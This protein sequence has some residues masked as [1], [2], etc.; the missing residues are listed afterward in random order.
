MK[1]DIRLH[2]PPDRG[3]DPVDDCQFPAPSDPQL[4]AEG[5]LR[6]HV[7]DK[8]R[9][10][11]SIELYRS[12]GFEVRTV[13]LTDPE[14]AKACAGCAPAFCGSHVVIYTRKIN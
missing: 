4:V 1:K 12:L 14:F 2:P 10:E 6:R 3:E 5:W 8:E 7:V 9:A 13:K 11:E